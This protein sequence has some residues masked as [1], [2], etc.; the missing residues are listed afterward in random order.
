MTPE[1]CQQ[2]WERKVS[3]SP[4]SQS[5]LE[6]IEEW[7][8]VEEEWEIAEEMRKYE[9]EEKRRME[10]MEREARERDGPWPDNEEFDLDDGYYLDG[11]AYDDY[12]E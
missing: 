6:L 11:K 1:E 2:W 10:E 9:E 8:R 4:A 5:R 7:E 3:A 12:E